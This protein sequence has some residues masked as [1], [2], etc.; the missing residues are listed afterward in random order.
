[1][2][3]PSA[4]LLALP[5][6]AILP[7]ALRRLRQ[8]A[9][10]SD[11]ATRQIRELTTLLDGLLQHTPLAVVLL[12]PEHRVRT[13]NP[14]F[15]SLFGYSREAILGRDLDDLIGG[16][17]FDEDARRITA[18]V[19]G[20]ETVYV[21][22]RRQRAGGELVDVEIYGIPL[23]LEQELIGVF[24]LYHDI[25]ERVEAERTLRDSEERFRRL[26]Q[27]TF[28]GICVFE[29][30][31]IVDANEQFARLF[32]FT[33]DEVIGAPI[34]SRVAKAQK[35]MVI[36][37]H[38]AGYDEPYEITCYKKDR[39]PFTVELR[40]RSIPYKGG[41]ARVV[42]MRDTSER[43]H[44]EAQLRQAQKMEAIGRVTAGIAHDFN[45]LL[46]A[47]L[48]Y[49]E[50]LRDRL[51]PGDPLA[52]YAE[53]IVR[54]SGRA[55]ELTRQLLAFGR[56]Q[57]LRTEPVELNQVV[58]NMERMLRRLIREDV[59]LVIELEP[60]STTI[61]A[62]LGQ[63][64]QVVL[65]LAINARDAMPRGGTLTLKTEG[66]E[67]GPADLA[68]DPD[69]VPGPYVRLTVRDT[70]VGMD[71]ET[72]GRIFEPFFTTKKRGEGT[73]LGLAMVYGIVKQS[74][75]GIAV[76]SSPG[77]GTTFHLD[78]P[79]AAAR[80]AAPPPPPR[81]EVDVDAGG[82]TVL[83]V[84]DEAMVS[85]LVA[86]CLESSGYRVLRAEDPQ[87]A[88]QLLRR[89]PTAVDLLLTDLVMPGMS[90]FELAEE[91][92]RRQPGLKVLYM[93]GYTEG[94]LF[95]NHRPPAP[96][97]LLRKPFTPRKLIRKVRRVLALAAETRAPAD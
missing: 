43:R 28:E 22:T 55:G 3:G 86:E 64:E 95:D 25:R 49:G 83:V 5:L 20:G 69:L 34:G 8:A 24:A 92:R 1:M 96:E 14:A 57:P 90:G 32:G 30:G 74:G 87:R 71:A 79:R 44:L 89:Q 94:A 18:R 13:C 41:T 7:A 42:V 61:E 12:D 15:E 45:N 56:R 47:I 9:T 46:T 91:M 39:T 52:R 27:A 63:L 72:R 38:Q 77:R 35:Q 53:E 21:T 10:G 62:D 93:S 67:L 16:P 78:F 60:G 84:D 70:G 88:L 23:M 36:D 81:P 58:T 48:S 6:V 51:P 85:S 66:R 76:T 17:R 75:G 2:P 4:T 40:G 19:R 54:A 73:G 11:D 31:K 65:N 50:L 29:D 37:R 68:Y 59:E 82:A 80:R 33:V 97:Q 26:A